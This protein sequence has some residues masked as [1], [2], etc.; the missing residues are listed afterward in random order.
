MNTK[1]LAIAVSTVT[2]VAV[3]T[4]AFS[5]DP[6]TDYVSIVVELG[7]VPAVAVAAK[8]PRPAG[9]PFDDAVHARTVYESQRQ[10]FNRLVGMGIDFRLS[11]TAHRTAAGVIRKPNRFYH[12]INAV[13]LE[14]PP[15]AVEVIR[16]LPSVKHLTLDKPVHLDLDRSVEYIRA[17]DGPGNKTIFTQ[18]GELKRF[19][20]TGQ[21]IAILDTGIEHTHPMFDTRFP[22]ADFTQR[23]GDTRPVRLAGQSYIEGTHHPKVVYF[24]ALTG[25]SNEDDVG[26]G[27]HGAADAAGLMVQAPGLD[28]VAGNADDKIIEGVAPGALLMNYKICETVFSCVGS[29]NIVAALEDA[30]SPVDPAG[31]PKPIATVIN[32]SFGGGGSPNDASAVAASNAALLGAVMVGSAG[33]SGLDGE[34]TVGAPAAG[35]RVIAVAATNDP[36]AVTNEVDVLLQDASRY[37]DAGASTGAQ[38]DTGRTVAPEDRSIH[39]VILGGSPDVAFPL[40]Q[41]YVYVGLADTPDQV[42]DEVAGR[43]ALAARGG[44]AETDAT[45][46]GLFGHKAAEVVA[47]G[48][49]ALLVFNN[50]DGELENATTQAATIPCYGLSKANGEFLRDLLGFQSAG[51]DKDDPATWGTISNF[52]IRIDPPEPATFSAQTTD[53]SSRGPVDNFQF[54]KPDLTAPGLTVYSATIPAGGLQV[55]PLPPAVGGTM[56]DPSRYIS[57]SG[58]SFSGPHVSGVAALVRGALIELRGQTP[59][60]AIALRSGAAATTQQAQ[61]ELVPQS[62]VRAVMTNTATNL[63]ELDNV[64]PVPDTDDRTFIHETG[65]GLVHVVQAVDARAVMGTDI[66]NGPGGPDDA[67]G[68]DF[69]PTHSFGQNPVINTA[70]PDQTSSVTVTIENLAGLT[71]AGTYE[72]TLLDGG[73]IRGDVTRPIAGTTGW[74]VDLSTSSVV[75]GDNVGDRAVFDVNVHVDGRPFPAGL[76][77]AGTDVTSAAATEFLWWVVAGG[78]NGEA[79]RMPFYYRAAVTPAP[80]TREAPFQLAIRD[81]D[82]PDQVSGADVDGNYR[83]AWTYPGPPAE[84]PCSFQ[85]EEA[86]TFTTVFTDDAEE[87]L[88]QGDN[89]TWDGDAAWTTQIHPD[90]GTNGYS[91]D[92]TNDQNASLRLKNAIAIPPATAAILSFDSSEDIEPDFDFGLVEVSGDGG[93]FILLASYTGSFSGRRQVDM[94][95]FAG[96][97]VIVQFRFV[98]DELVSSPVHL[99]WFIDNVEVQFAD[100]TLIGTVAADTFQLDVAGRGNGAY[101][102]RVAGRFSD[103]CAAIGPFSNLRSVS[104]SC[105]DQQIHPTFGGIRSV[106]SASRGVC[107]L[108]LAWGEGF[109][110]CL[111]GDVRYNVYRGSD[112]DFIPDLQNLLALSL[113]GLSYLDQA[114]LADGGTYYYIVRA[115][116]NATGGGGP[117]NGGH[118]DDNLV[119]VGGAP[120]GPLAPVGDFADDVEPDAEPGYVTQTNR[121]AAGWQVTPDTTASS[122]VQSWFAFDEQPSAPPGT[123]GDDRLMLPPMNLSSASVLTFRHNYDL[124]QFPEVPPVQSAAYHSGGVLELSADGTNWIDLGPYITVN[125]YTGQIAADAMNPLVDRPAWV[126]SSDATAGDRTDAMTEV[127]VDLGAAVTDPNAF[128]ASA[129]MGAR[130][131]FRL[132]GTFQI[133][134]GGVQGT[135]WGVDD[136]HVS[137]LLEPGPCTTQTCGDGVLD[138]GEECDDRAYNSDSRADACRTDCVAA[139]CGDAVLDSGDECDDGSIA[140]GD[141]CSSTCAVEDQFVCT[142]QPS[143]CLPDC[144][145]NSVPDETERS[146]CDGS[147]A[148]SDCNANGRLDECDVAPGGGSGDFNG[149]GVPDECECTVASSAVR[150]TVLDANGASVGSAK[151]RFLSFSAGEPGSRSAVRV[152]FLNLPGDF[153]VFNGTSAWV[154]EPQTVSELPSK[155][156]TDPVGAEGAFWAAGL[157]DTPVFADWSTFGTVHVYDERIIPSRRRPNQPLEPAVYE[158]H[159]LTEGCD[160]GAESGY[161]PALRITNA[162]WA[163]MAQLSDGQ[164]RA[165][166][167]VVS[168]DDMLAVVSKFAGVAAAPIKARADLLGVG[169]VGPTPDVD[170]KI[171]ISDVIA[172]VDAFAGETYPFAASAS[173]ASAVLGSRQGSG[174]GKVVTYAPTPTRGSRR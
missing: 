88:V 64:T 76:A 61:N 113:S 2:L 141:G 3:H 154:A 43:I 144:N 12:L 146:G 79:L 93:P 142:G 56:S 83:V 155:G 98:S 30:M 165:P 129:L 86:T 16:K 62:L 31:F 69:L 34:N 169:Q 38:D 138:A 42:P 36:N 60:D 74:S 7:D 68:G 15:G 9:T 13:G 20:G 5:A 48:A 164:F 65:S 115:E 91:P 45:G 161:S 148:C 174:V 114:G 80:A 105:D 152:S 71:G 4:H 8:R 39:A 52:P 14:V 104:V 17:N 173:P 96:Q 84:A 66:S 149:N 125:G 77:V 170:G 137:H 172:V 108:D 18:T 101:T 90:T 55:Q 151:S 73:A 118:E 10:F 116:D 78:S 85:V 132:G 107:G 163:D 67:A 111:P 46:T 99:G 47:K 160:P 153:S 156:L 24:L 87:A 50:V 94:S 110:H 82:P 89:S 167:G 157:S 119:R 147:P 81:D 126:G 21:V 23:T 158:I 57:A 29:V 97:N 41:H 150:D 131:R 59:I 106:S 102:Y 124:A 103:P 128:N 49:V 166:D 11:E 1:A 44:T 120:H 75:L 92:Y 134:A 130:I 33:N 22:D 136:I 109:S 70:I 63:R 28:R 19:D 127:S 139:H 135:G 100:W 117:A 159:V 53:F 123:P 95:G 40:G 171:T 25:S 37:T 140:D 54:L 168:V 58:T 32:M 143:V 121:A 72:L 122:P 27:T 145:R 162:R 133:L 6:L 51:F 26:H 112:P 35:H